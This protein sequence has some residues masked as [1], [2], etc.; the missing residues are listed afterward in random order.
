M[1]KNIL[2]EHIKNTQSVK[3]KLIKIYKSNVNVEDFKKI[4]IDK[5]E[6]FK[7]KNIM[8]IKNEMY[9]YL[10]VDLGL[11]IKENSIDEVYQLIWNHVID[12]F[13]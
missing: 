10:N 4:D 1:K 6:D 2:V 7:N 12:E 3:K 13:L 9:N 5:L 11:E 8:I